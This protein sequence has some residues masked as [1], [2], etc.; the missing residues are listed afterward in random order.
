[1][2]GPKIIGQSGGKAQQITVEV[3]DEI[4]GEVTKRTLDVVLTELETI[5]G[6]LL[7]RAIDGPT[8]ALNTPIDSPE[9]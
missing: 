7:G 3:I 5:G 2:L 4:T 6:P 1:M 9:N 8:S